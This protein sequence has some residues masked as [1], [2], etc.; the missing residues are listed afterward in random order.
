M[1]PLSKALPSS[2]TIGPLNWYI[3]L[4][5]PSVY[6]LVSSPLAPATRTSLNLSWNFSTNSGR[7]GSVSLP[8]FA[9]S[10]HV[11]WMNGA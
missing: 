2:W 11:A 8:F 1:A 6:G 9:A 10:F 5:M 3:S 4:A 7:N